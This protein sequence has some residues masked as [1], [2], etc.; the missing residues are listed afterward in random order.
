M[1]RDSC[2][3][4]AAGAKGDRVSDRR[5]QGTI[6]AT[7]L[8]ATWALRASISVL[9]LAAGAVSLR[10]PVLTRSELAVLAALP[11]LAAV[12]IELGRRAEGGLV[13]AQRPH[14]GLSAWPFAAVL[15]C[16]GSLA[17]LV[18][19]PVYAYARWRGMRVPL[20]KWVGSGAIVILAAA[21]AQPLAPSLRDP[22]PE[23]LLALAAAAGV[24]L[25]VEAGAFGL[26]AISG[27]PVDEKWLKEQLRSRSFYTA[28]FAVLC[29]ATVVAVVWTATPALVLALL[30]SY[31]VLQRALLHAPLR[32]AADTDAKTGLLQLHAWQARAE[33]L[34]AKEIA[35]SVVLIDLD[36]FK[37]VNDRHG[38][39]MGDEV[40]RSCADA[41][42]GVLRP[43]D[44]LGRFGGEEFCLLLPG[45][46]VTE[47]LHVAE[48][49]RTALAARPLDCLEVTAS[50]GVFASGPMDPHRLREALAF[51]DLALYAAKDAGRD[52][53]RSHRPAI[54]PPAPRRAGDQRLPA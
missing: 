40:L 41:F 12:D 22:G 11:L 28:E 27:E 54:V 32:K 36:H 47:A 23:V 10:S 1:R 50:F 15:L 7:F 29:Q 43:T 4:D 19:V 5:R 25:L 33:A 52:T 49:M 44:L 3:E 37:A 42:A 8:S 17:A 48:R 16:G 51:A 31:A 30:P 24:F 35:F 6:S 13:A 39:L 26:C 21:A 38:H 53:V 45:S 9:V 46:D 34:L 2:V 20:F 18:I 14:K